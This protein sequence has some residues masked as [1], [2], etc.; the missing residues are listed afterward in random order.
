MQL[1]NTANVL[2]TAYAK[3]LGKAKRE[4]NQKD[5]KIPTLTTLETR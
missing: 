2:N 1:T 4:T 5:R 3:A